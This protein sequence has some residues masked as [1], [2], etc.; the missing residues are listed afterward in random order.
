MKSVSIE[1][2]PSRSV[3][4]QTKMDAIK[5][6]CKSATKSYCKPTVETQLALQAHQPLGGG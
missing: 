6:K 4:D 1:I 2:E 5:R 3:F